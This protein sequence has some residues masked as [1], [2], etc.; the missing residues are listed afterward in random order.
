MQKIP[1]TRARTFLGKGRGRRPL[2][3][4]KKDSKHLTAPGPK[5]RGGGRA[6]GKPVGSGHIGTSNKAERGGNHP[7]NVFYMDRHL[8]AE[9]AIFVPSHQV[10]IGAKR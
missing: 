10:A 8:D 5:G 4:I 6:G 9:T 2:E 1:L 7:G 3:M